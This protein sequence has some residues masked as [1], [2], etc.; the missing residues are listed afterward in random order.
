MANNIDCMIIYGT[1][2]D[3]N[4]PYMYV[5]PAATNLQPANKTMDY[6]GHETGKYVVNLASLPVSQYHVNNAIVL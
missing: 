3:V 6:W 2:L 1:N 5:T 4:T